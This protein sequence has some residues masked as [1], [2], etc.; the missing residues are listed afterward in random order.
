MHLMGRR[1]SYWTDM[2]TSTP[3]YDH[4]ERTRIKYTEAVKE[5]VLFHRIGITS[6]PAEERGKRE[7][8]LTIGVKEE[9]TPEKVDELDKEYDG[10]KLTYRYDPIRLTVEWPDKPSKKD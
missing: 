8:V 3:S 9:L 10:V 2:L 4:V 1:E 6:I 5:N 7:V